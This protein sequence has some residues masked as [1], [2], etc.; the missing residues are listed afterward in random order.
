MSLSDY[1][2]I[3]GQFFKVVLENLFVDIC[4]KEQKLYFLTFDCKG[5]KRIIYLSHL[6]YQNSQKRKQKRKETIGCCHPRH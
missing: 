4:S 3:S 6:S 2:I 5:Q 1:K